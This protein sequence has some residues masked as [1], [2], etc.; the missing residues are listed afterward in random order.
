MRRNCQPKQPIPCSVP[1][2]DLIELFVR[3]LES[4]GMQTYMI[5]GSVASIE[6]GEPRATLDVDIAIQLDR[7]QAARVPSL[8]PESDYY[9]PPLEVLEIE[10]A[11]RTRGHFNIIHS[12]TGLK[13]DF[14][15]STNHPYFAWALKARR[16]WNLLGVD[17]WIAPPEYVILWK[18]EF[19][20]EGGGEKHVRDIRGI[21]AVTA[22][23]LTFLNA[24]VSELDLESA[25]K[26][27]HD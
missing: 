12:N 22:V 9:C 18:L 27:C 7:A 13:A 4:A 17:V 3:P 11:R 6:Y 8:F 19:F 25:W 2:P 26:A 23:D 14:Y 15:P 21:L 20:R 1:E 24:A 10:L 16:R 5:S